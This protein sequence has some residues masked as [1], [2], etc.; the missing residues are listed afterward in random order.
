MTKVTIDVGGETMEQ[1]CK[2]ALVISIEP[3]EENASYSLMLGGETNVMQVLGES[4][5][6]IGGYIR[7]MAK[8]EEGIELLYKIFKKSL[9][10]SVT[11]KRGEYRV[12]KN[13]VIPVEK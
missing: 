4:A 10:R 5:T 3:T 7:S 1:E 6:A 13:V 11:G 9:K 2:A 12:E 8:N